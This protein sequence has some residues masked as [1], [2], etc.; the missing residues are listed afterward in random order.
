MSKR[1]SFRHSAVAVAVAVAVAAI[2]AVLPTAGFANTAGLPSAMSSMLSELLADEAALMQPAT[3]PGLSSERRA[4]TPFE[5]LP[6][7]ASCTSQCRATY[8]SCLD[9]CDVAPFPGCADHCRF[10]VLYPCYGACF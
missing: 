6:L 5:P 2:V 7:A 8:L 10:D 9:D 3:A 1:F 4:S